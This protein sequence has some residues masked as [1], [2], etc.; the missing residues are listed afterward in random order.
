MQF[1]YIR[2]AIPRFLPCI[3]GKGAGTNVAEAAGAG[4]EYRA[5]VWGHDDHAGTF[6]SPTEYAFLSGHK[7]AH[8]ATGRLTAREGVRSLQNFRGQNLRNQQ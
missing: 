2:F 7:G 5:S 3:P 6:S 4:A 8:A 1:I